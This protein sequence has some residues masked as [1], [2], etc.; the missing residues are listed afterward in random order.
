MHPRDA[1][2]TP[3]R[4]Y[5]V[6]MPPHAAAGRPASAPAFPP[7]EPR[8]PARSDWGEPEW[9][10]RRRGQAQAEQQA[11]ADQSGDRTIAYIPE[12]PA[13][14]EP[15]GPASGPLGPVSGPQPAMR[16]KPDEPEW[17]RERRQR[18]GTGPQKA[19]DLADLPSLPEKISSE[20]EQANYDFWKEDDDERSAR[21]S[22]WRRSRRDEDDEDFAPPPPRR[23]PPRREP[24]Y[25]AARDL[26][27]SAAPT[28]YEEFR[29]KTA[30]IGAA[31][32]PAADDRRGRS[33]RP[34]A[35]PEAWSSGRREPPSRA[36]KAGHRNAWIAGIIV[37]VLTLLIIA[38]GA[39]H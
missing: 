3:N 7:D 26:G 20:A 23:E 15:P 33:R 10:K 13:A 27:Y 19:P 34:S 21:R 36:K 1:L 22:R 4:A 37:V 39:T 2:S 31:D 11:Q 6:P 35:A 29:A 16:P 18:G 24:D 12:R 28:S 32:G 9:L 17:L 5:R 14:P 38:I 25:D 30:T 8:P